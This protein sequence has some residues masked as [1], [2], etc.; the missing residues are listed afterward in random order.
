[1]RTLPFRDFV[2]L[3]R[4][5]DLP[6]AQRQAGPY[7]VIAS[8]S[9]HGSH[10]EYKVEKP[11]V[12]TGRSGSLGTV[13]YV[14]EPFWP[15][16]T[17]L[18]VKDFKGN[19]PRYVYYFLQM[20]G[21]EQYNAGT[22]VP[23]LNR[24]HLDEL[25][26]R[27]HA[28]QEQVTIAGVLQAYDELIEN[29]LRRIAILEEMARTTYREWFVNFR[30]PGHGTASLTDSPL[31]PIPDGWNWVQLGKRVELKYGKALRAAERLPG[32]VPVYGSGGIVGY[33]DTSLVKGPGVVVGR[34]GNVG[35][36]HW[37][38]D[39]FYPIDTTYYVKSDLP[40]TYLNFALKD[41]QFIDSHAAVPGLSRSQAYA[42][43]L[44]I[45]HPHLLSQFDAAIKEMFSAQRNLRLQITN[46]RASRDLLLPKL[47]SGEIDVSEIAIHTPWLDP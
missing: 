10:S 37:S 21:L 19:V 43:P 34:K 28:Y 3:K 5:F 14:D 2:Q 33:H 42:T 17:T 12:V 35:S 9:I 15:L 26:L 13:L 16:N 41:Q 30:F 4:G 23:T 25:L 47:I 45:P 29:N 46:L 32:P 40:L 20:L 44:L 38:D 36:I 39:D 6:K 1:M 18:W 8:T 11:G 31:G 27:V 24:N 22:G 7:P